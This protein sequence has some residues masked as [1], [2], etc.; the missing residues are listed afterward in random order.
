MA[1][2]IP[3]SMILR[4]FTPER[5]VIE[6]EVDAVTAPGIEGEFGVLPGHIPFI[7]TLKI[8]ELAFRSDSRVERI[9]LA[10]GYV[11]VLPDRVTV[12]AELPK[13]RTK[14]ILKGP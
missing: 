9:A 10:W 11:E 7:T 6:A 1:E 2:Q 3:K 5:K 4:L 8:G 14:S 12:L 13:W